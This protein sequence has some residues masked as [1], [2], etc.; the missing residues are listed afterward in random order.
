MTFG[1]VFLANWLSQPLLGDE[2]GTR[3]SRRLTLTLWPYLVGSTFIT[4]SGLL[5]RAGSE[6]AVSAAVATFAGTLFLAYIPLFF[7]GDAFYPGEPV[8]G[9]A[10]P[11]ERSK[12][13]LIAGAL[14]LVL[15]LAVFGPGL[16]DFP[17]P[18]PLDPS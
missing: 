9:P 18:H 10:L 7:R 1:T 3:N 15:G 16:G 17:T 2:A 13:W 5:S 14:S 11:I 4:A 12:P 8:R 6:Y